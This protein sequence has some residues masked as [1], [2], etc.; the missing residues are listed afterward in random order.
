MNDVNAINDRNP[1][2]WDSDKPTSQSDAREKKSSSEFPSTD[3]A[4][5]NLLAR[6]G[7]EEWC[8]KIIEHKKSNGVRLDKVT[9]RRKK[10]QLINQINYFESYLIGNPSHRKMLRWI[11]VLVQVDPNAIVRH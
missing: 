10:K 3:R 5:E 2:Q 4:T 6:A 1:N 8:W 7:S 9:Q 11:V